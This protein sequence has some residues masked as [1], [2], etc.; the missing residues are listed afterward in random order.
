MVFNRC[1]DYQVARPVLVNSSPVSDE[2]P[3]PRFLVPSIST[4]SRR[5]DGPWQASGSNNNLQVRIENS[6]CF[7]FYSSRNQHTLKICCR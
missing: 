3:I 4:A 1:C 5:Q 2:F 6:N 7:F